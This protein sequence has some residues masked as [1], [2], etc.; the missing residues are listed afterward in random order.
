MTPAVSILMPLRDDAFLAPALG[1][2][3]SQSFDDFELVVIDDSGGDALAPVIRRIWGEED[4]L[5]IFPH[6]GARGLGS[7]LNDGRAHCRAPL[8]ARADGDDLYDPDR[9]KLQVEEMRAR[10][11]LVA[12]SSGWKR[13]DA[14]GRVLYAHRPATGPDRLRL[15]AMF[16]APLLHPGAMIRASALDKAGGYDPALWTAQDSDLWN[17][18]AQVGQIDNL[19]RPLVQWRAHG[20]SVLARRGAEGARLSQRV[21]ARHIGAYLGR[22][23]STLEAGPALELWK[24]EGTGSEDLLAEIHAHAKQAERSEVARDFARAVAAAHLLRFRR[25]GNP[26]HAL[27]AMR[28]TL[29]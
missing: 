22:P 24:S 15:R 23:V 10:P 1:S 26:R 6:E 28:W 3:R 8:I 7:V 13:I 25:S 12:L 27:G 14:E 9:L 4:R 18:L 2:L 29:K 5:H 20:G 19:P 11:D 17:R 16:G 21:A